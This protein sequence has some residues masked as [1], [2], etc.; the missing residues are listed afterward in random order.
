MPI[1][2]REL[3]IK[4]TVLDEAPRPAGPLAPAAGLTAAHAQLRQELAHDLTQDCVRQ[5][6]AE[7]QR[8][9]ER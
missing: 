8:R 5:V 4:V 9:R 1:E 7:L 6:L 3:L 2:I